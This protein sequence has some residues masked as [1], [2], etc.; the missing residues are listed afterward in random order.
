MKYTLNETLLNKLPTPFVQTLEVFF[1]ED[2]EQQAFRSV[3][4]LIDAIEV[5]CKLYTVASVS[6]FLE[7]LK[8]QIDSTNTLNEKEFEKIKVMLAAGLKTPSLGIW[9]SF[10]RDT[11]KVLNA[12]NYNTI[13]PDFNQQ[14][15]HKNSKIKK[16]FDGAYKIKKYVCATADW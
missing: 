5:F 3:H 6:T 7:V 15:T 10:A 12:I 4:R 8:E 9:W 1:K 14:L 13:L 16:A 2:H 11:A